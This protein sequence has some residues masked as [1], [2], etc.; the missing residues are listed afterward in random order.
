MVVGCI[1]DCTAAA[2]FAEYI[3]AEMAV[4][5]IV[6]VEAAVHTSVAVAEVLVVADNLCAFRNLLEFAR[7][8]GLKSAVSY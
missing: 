2:R 5:D 4:E 8:V 3:V 1:V 6:V 7:I